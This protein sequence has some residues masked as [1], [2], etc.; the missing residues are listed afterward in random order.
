MNRNDEI[1]RLRTRLERLEAH[2]GLRPNDFQKK[3]PFYGFTP[4]SGMHIL[5]DAWKQVASMD[6]QCMWLCDELDLALES[7][8]ILAPDRSRRE[9]KTFKLRERL[10]RSLPRNIGERQLEWN[11]YNRWGL[12]EEGQDCDI[13]CWKRLVGFQIPVYDNNLHDGWDKIDLVGV[14]DEGTPV[15]VELKKGSS[16]EKPLRPLLEVAAYA[17]ALKKVWP[18]F[19]LELTNLI[20]ELNLKLEVQP[21]PEKFHLVVLA[22]SEYWNRIR[23]IKAITREKWTHFS[24][25]IRMLNQKDFPVSFIEV[26]ENDL[27]IKKADLPL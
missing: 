3:P 5:K 11:I 24:K 23:N 4:A 15:I 21:S 27:I 2:L 8:R 18:A 12:K 14:D 6:K 22:P 19:H 16:D 10:E 7:T 1:Q 13:N 26:H 25:L 20:H 9:N 17:I